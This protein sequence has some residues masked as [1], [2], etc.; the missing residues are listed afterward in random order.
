M[1]IINKSN[2][3]IFTGGP[4]AGKTS[5]LN[6]LKQRGYLTVEEV[7]RKIIKKQHATKGN[8]T[9]TGNRIAYCDLMLTASITDYKNH[10]P[11]S[12]IVFFDRGIPDLYSYSKRF[13]NGVTTA[14]E[15]AIRYHRYNPKVFLFPTW[16]DIYCHDT[17]RKQSIEEAIETY[18]ALKEGY[19]TCGY[20][21]IDVPK[22]SIETRADFILKTI[23]E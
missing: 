22:G 8:A 5:V 3:F 7:A 20:V 19:S 10:I 17:E 21:V 11:R 13:C 4:G 2:F 16:T 6:A 9:H 15:N 23:S 14:I 18:H 1:E 12:E